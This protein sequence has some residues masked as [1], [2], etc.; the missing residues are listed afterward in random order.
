MNEPWLTKPE[1]AARLKVSPRTL[2]R[3]AVPHQRIGGQNRYRA[4]EVE[5]YFRVD[6]EADAGQLPSNVVELPRRRPG[7]RAA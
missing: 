3:Y 2:E 4:S 7:G 6:P 1:M 5:R